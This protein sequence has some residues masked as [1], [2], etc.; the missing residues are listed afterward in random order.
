MNEFIEVFDSKSEEEHNKQ[1][2][3]VAYKKLIMKIK[4][5]LPEAQKNNVTRK[6]NN[7]RG[8]IYT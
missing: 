3:A 4:E 7:L 1:L 2:R 8:H 6:I 5:V